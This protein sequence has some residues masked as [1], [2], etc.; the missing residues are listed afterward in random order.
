LG[1]DV[2]QNKGFILNA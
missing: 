2:K 1:A